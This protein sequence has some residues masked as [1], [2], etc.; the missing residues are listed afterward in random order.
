[1]GRGTCRRFPAGPAE[2]GSGGAGT[3]RFYANL[4]AL[5]QV[6]LE[7]LRAGGGDRRGA[8]A[9]D[10]PTQAEEAGPSPSPPRG[11]EGMAVVSTKGFTR[12]SGSGK[13]MVEFFSAAIS[14]SV[15]R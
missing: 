13:T 8:P 15:W 6:I 7:V 12:S 11:F 1:M 4:G 2:A 10:G 5:C 9:P 3:P 14:V